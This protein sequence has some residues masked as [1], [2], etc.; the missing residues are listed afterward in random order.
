MNDD[1]RYNLQDP[2]NTAALAMVI[3]CSI[4]A[5]VVECMLLCCKA[6]ARKVPINY[7]LLAIFTG[8]WAFIMT[9]IC[10]QYDKTTVL[11][12]ALYTAVITVV[13]SLYACFTKADFTKL[14]GRW[15][16][17]ALLLIIT[18]Q[19]MLSI[20]SMLI[21]DYTDT[22][23]PLAAG[24]CVILYGLFLII[25][26]QL[27]IGGKRHELSIDDY[28]VGALILY[29]DIIMIFLELLKIFGGR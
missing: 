19:L 14:C 4:V 20:I 15:T 10:A 17:F 21:F 13:L 22:W 2:D 18:V 23:V 1:M 12:A 9:W 5:I 24:F 28:V 11:S 25:D 7:I 26:T 27:I 16:I 29:I 8:C 6:N 3:V